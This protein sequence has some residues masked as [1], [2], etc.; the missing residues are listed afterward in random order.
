MAGVIS[1]GGLATGLDTNTIVD[2]LVALERRPIDLLTQD[3][4]RVD[5]NKSS[6]GELSSRLTAVQTAA[7]A[8]STTAGV[9][10]RKATSSNDSV[11][12]AAAGEG[13]DRASAAITVTQL[14]RGS[15]STSTI[16]LGSATATVASGAGT[17]SF[18]VGTG[19]VQSVSVD[20]TTTLQGLAGSINEL[21][22]GVTASVVNLGTGATP[23]YRL[24][25]SSSTTG[26]SST[27]TVLHDDTA[28]AVQ[29][30]QTGQNAQFTVAG[31]TG[32]F[33]RET[34][35]VTDV[36]TGVTLSLKATG[37]ATVAVNDDTDAIVAKVKALVGAFNSA[38]SFVKQ[39]ATI[40]QTKNGSDLQLGTLAADSSA[41]RVID[42]LHG[43]FSSAITGA[44]GQYV[45]LSSLGMATTKEG[46]IA[47]NEATFRTAL[48]SDA[49]GVA[50]VF[51]GNG[52]ASGIAT[53]LADFARQAT[54]AGGLL[55]IRTH[56]LDE[57]ER[58]IQ[59][60]IDTRQ[61]ALDAFRVDLQHQF[62]SLENLV[63]SLKTQGSFLSSA[64]K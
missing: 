61:R 52:T 39:E 43:I 40:G 9:L 1:I 44:S 18:Q 36:L 8:L 2:K 28:L 24:A 13:A 10:V 46:T 19:S 53:D 23:D 42:Q 31:F 54:Q 51:A 14:A 29:T 33:E 6:I 63:N 20:A 58:S 7:K 17:F 34:N 50:Q 3:F 57:T 26:A 25:L 5:A 12:S 11:L 16:G 60:Q 27:V 48:A 64:F 35:T 56:T 38:V 4:D 30:T 15:V 49:T 45:N 47:L 55:D 21:N 62:T 22:A 59:D 37:T 32:T 41:R